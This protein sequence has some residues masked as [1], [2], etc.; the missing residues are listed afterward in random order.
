MSYRRSQSYPTSQECSSVYWLDEPGP[1][2]VEFVGRVSEH[3][4]KPGLGFT[5]NP[6]PNL[7][8]VKLELSKILR[9]SRTPGPVSQVSHPILQE[10]SQGV[11]KQQIKSRLVAR[12]KKHLEKKQ[13]VVAAFKSGNTNTASLAKLTKL[14]SKMVNR[15][16]L[17]SE[18]LDLQPSSDRL[19]AELRKLDQISEHVKDQTDPFFTIGS[20]KR[21]LKTS[22]VCASRRLISKVIKRYN[23]RWS[24]LKPK[25]K[26]MTLSVINQENLSQA[27]SILSL[28]AYSLQLRNSVFFTDEIKLNVV[29]GPSKSWRPAKPG[30]IY[31]RSQTSIM[32]TCIALSSFDGFLAVQF[33]L[34]ELKSSDYNQFLVAVDKRL[35]ELNKEYRLILDS[36]PWHAS[37]EVKSGPL[38][39]RLS[40]N[41]KGLY[42]A[43]LIEAQFSFVR[44]RWRQRPIVDTLQGEV[45]QALNIFR[46]FNEKKFGKSYQRRYTKSAISI[47]QRIQEVT[48]QIDGL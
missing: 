40:F 32:L 6:S 7:T 15:I 5:V 42:A 33:F 43:N 34:K 38:Q 36:A 12:L 24:S 39:H 30:Q 44:G 21:K 11:K 2:T 1:E 28:M 19:D 20:I 3:R 16:M 10:V 23:L 48:S 13:K 45:L 29:Q 41:L 47:L 8:R 25:P 31:A 35:V 27:K 18:V 14:P 22:Q 26:S 4:I 37:Q 9:D 17:S 46:E